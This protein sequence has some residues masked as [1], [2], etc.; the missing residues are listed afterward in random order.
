MEMDV[1]AMKRREK[2]CRM[3]L[4]E[5]HFGE[6]VYLIPLFGAATSDSLCEMGDMMDKG[7]I[8]ADSKTLRDFCFRF[9][10]ELLS[11]ENEVTEDEVRDLANIKTISEMQDI[12]L[13]SDDDSKKN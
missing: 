13:N 11:I 8:T 7:E 4:R 1:E 3:G 6:K 10:M 5:W 2:I 12:W 9:A